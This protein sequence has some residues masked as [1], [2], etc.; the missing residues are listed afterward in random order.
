MLRA[1][2]PRAAITKF[3]IFHRAHITAPPCRPSGAVSCAKLYALLVFMRIL[4]LLPLYADDAPGMRLAV[5]ACWSRVYA[6]RVRRT[7]YLILFTIYA[8]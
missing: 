6:G 8:L 2:A 7:I 1:R 4:A 5:E 3:K